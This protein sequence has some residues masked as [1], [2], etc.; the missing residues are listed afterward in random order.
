M[1]TSRLIAIALIVAGA[2]GLAYGGFT[3]TQQ[4]HE[5]EL[6]PI[7]F[8]VKENKTVNIPTWLGGGTLLAGVLLLASA[9]RR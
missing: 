5:A 7:A 4:T 9:K 2:L 1:N 3:Y 6:G 8:S